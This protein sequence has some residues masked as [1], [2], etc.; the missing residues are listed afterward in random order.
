MLTKWI[1]NK[2]QSKEYVLLIKYIIKVNFFW[3]VP[4]IRKIM[5]KSLYWRHEK[6]NRIDMSKYLYLYSQ[7]KS[8]P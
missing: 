4:E 3:V 1:N 5:N 7:Q 8:K 2:L 6:I